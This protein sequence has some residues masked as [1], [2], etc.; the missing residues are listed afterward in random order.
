LQAVAEGDGLLICGAGADVGL[1]FRPGI[2]RERNRDCRNLAALNRVA[3][4]L[5]SRAGGYGSAAKQPERIELATRCASVRDKKRQ[6]AEI[7]D[8]FV[9]LGL[10]HRL[11]GGKFAS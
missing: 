4:M 1:T 6:I 10:A 2:P 9:S 7:L 3:S 8:A 11:R 5:L